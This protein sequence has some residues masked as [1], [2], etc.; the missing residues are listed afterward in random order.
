MMDRGHVIKLTHQEGADSETFVMGSDAAEFVDKV[1]DQVRNRQKRMSNVAESGEEHSKI[2]GMFMAATLNA[3]TFMGKNFSTIQSFVKNYE[4]LTLKQMFDVTA[5][6]V[7]NQDEIN[8]LYKIQWEK[9]SWK[10]LSLIGD[11]TVINL[12]STKVY[13]FSDSVLCLGRVL[14]HPDSNEAWKNRVA[15]IQSVKS[16]RDYDGINGEST[17]FEWNIFPGF[18]TLQLCD[19]INDLPSDLGQTPET[20]TGRILFMSMF[21]DISCDRKGNKDECL[22]NAGV[23]KVLARRFG[24]GQWSF[25]G[26]GSEKKWYSSENSPQGAWDNIAE[27]MLLE[28]AES[29]HP[30]FRA[31][32]PLSRVQLKSKGRGKLSIH[33]AA[34][35]DTIDTIF[36]IILSVNQLSVYGA[37]AAICEEFE[38]HQDG[39]G[40]PEILIGQSIVLGE[41]KAEVPLQNENSMNDQI[42]RQQYI[43]RI[44]SLSPESKVSRF[45]K[46]AGFMRV[47]EVGQYL[48]TKDTGNLR[49]FRSVACR[50]YT[51]PR[52]DPAS[53]AKGW[54]QGN[55][56]IGP[57]YGIEIRILVCE[58]RQFSISG[59][60]ILWNDQIC[61]RSNSR[62][63]RNSDRS[64]RRASATNK[65]Q[66]CCSQ[67]KGKSKTT[68]ESTSWY[69]SNHTNA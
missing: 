45:C 14:Q 27:E 37:V 66:G 12:Q 40:E 52:D 69:N 19:K 7:N 48:V 41:I 33:F 4:D 53:E 24:V 57:V 55:M 58:S 17:E 22:A 11:E 56:R 25:L 29:G 9:N 61:G 13:V 5:Q 49:Q 15:G 44:E 6:L 10:R 47:V 23:V 30:T 8:G 67:I 20:F 39:S 1:K 65:H 21:N 18:T 51:L 43:E 32:T 59:Q 2:W 50:E 46:E 36:R 3:A 31:T 60:N 34:D 26:P 42:L 35:G 68:T 54:I 62:Q 38:S 63:Y 28:F 16:Y 64:T